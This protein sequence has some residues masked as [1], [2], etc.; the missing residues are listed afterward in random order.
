MICAS[1]M[2]EG[3][4]TDSRGHCPRWLVITMAPHGPA[5]LSP[6]LQA[7]GVSGAE[8]QAALP[9][10]MKYSWDMTF[11]RQRV[12]PPAMFSHPEKIGGCDRVLLSHAER[13]IAHGVQ[14]QS[15]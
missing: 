15:A 8:V 5:C 10:T 2:S 13:A 12:D 1:A 4:T 6:F 14:S 3:W 9:L 11:G 7:H